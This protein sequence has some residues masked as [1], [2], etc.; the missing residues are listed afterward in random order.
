VSVF[1]E[2]GTYYVFLLFAKQN[3]KQI[4]QIYVGPNFNPTTNVKFVRVKLPNS[5][6]VVTDGD[7]P[8]GWTKK[9]IQGPDKMETVLEVKTDF[10][11]LPAS[12]NFDPKTSPDTC[13][14][15]SFCKRDSTGNCGCNLKDD[16]PLL[17]S[18]MGLEATCTEVCKTWAVMD[19]DYPE[20]G[21]VG[22]SFTLPEKGSFKPDDKNHRPAPERFPTKDGTSPWKTV[23]FDAAEQKAA[24]DCYYTEAQTPA[25]TG[26]CQ[27]HD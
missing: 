13:K 11:T 25:L 5:N 27:P 20:G 7:W 19:V 26:Q 15:V 1:E 22:F 3:T 9:M 10:S 4:Y 14:P 23:K 21:A 2:G 17:A 8:A 16:S 6:F 24:G 12:I 18:H